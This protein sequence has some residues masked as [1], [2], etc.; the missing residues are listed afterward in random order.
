[1]DSLH[2]FSPAFSFRVSEMN[3]DSTKTYDVFASAWVYPL[4]KEE[5]KSKLVISF[6]NESGMIQWYGCPLKYFLPS[7]GQWTQVF[8]A[9]RTNYKFSGREVFKSY[10]VNDDSENFLMDDH[11]IKAAV[12]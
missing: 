4:Q 7:P 1:M 5:L 8:A 11:E 12:Y 6:E 10:I 9:L 2:S 3:L